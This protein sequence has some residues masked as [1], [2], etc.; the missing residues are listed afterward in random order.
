MPREWQVG[1]KTGT[2]NNG[3]TN[4]I[5]VVWPPD[6]PPIVVAAYLAESPASDDERNVVMKEIGRI[7]ATSF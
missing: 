3:V 1:D 6:R 5:A 2:G 7:V 4:D